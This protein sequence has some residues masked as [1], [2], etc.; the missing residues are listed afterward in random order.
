MMNVTTEGL[1]SMVQAGLDLDTPPTEEEVEQ[2]LARLVYAFGASEEIAEEAKR[3]LHARFELRMDQGQT[4]LGDEEHEPWLAARQAEIDPFYW[5]R[6]RKLLLRSGWGPRVVATLNNTLDE[7]LDLLGNPANQQPWKR[8]G[9][10]VGDVQSGKTATYAGL[11]NKASDAGY[12]M[13]I[14]LTG[15]LENVRRQ[16]QERLDAAFVGFDSRDYLTKGQLQHKTHIGVGQIDS[17]R[18]GVVFTSRDKDF[19]KNTASQLNIGLDSVKDPVLVV[20]KKNKAVLQRLAAWLKSRNADRDGGIDLPLLLIDDEADNASINTST[21]PK[22]TTAINAVIRDLLKLF[23]RSSYVGFTAT[24]FANIFIDPD[25]TDEWRDEDLFPKDFIHLLEPPNNYIGMETL[26]QDTDGDHEDFLE[27]GSILQ[28]IDDQNSWLPV[29]H[30]KGYEP[31]P[32]PPSLLEAVRWFLLTC[33]IRDL[34]YRGNHVGQG[35]PIHRSMLIN[36][37][38]FTD[39][40]DTVAYSVQEQLDNIQLAVR[41]HG[42]KPAAEAEKHSVEIAELRRVF[43]RQGQTCG[44]AWSSVLD[45]LHEAIAPVSVQPINQRTGSAVLDYG[46]R[47]DFPGIRVI[48]VGGNSLSRGITLEGLTVSYFLRNSKAYDTLLQMGRWFGYRDGYHDLCRLWMSEEAIG[49]YRHIALATAELKRDFRKMRL[50]KATP[51]EFG[52]RVRTHPDT[53][54]ITARNKMSSGVDVVEEVKEVSLTGRGIETARLHKRPRSNED[55]R[56]W[57]REFLASLSKDVSP[58][59]IGGHRAFCWKDVSA[60]KIADFAERFQVHPHNHDFQADSIAEHLRN[61]AH[62]SDNSWAYW[63]VIL[64]AKGKDKGVPW[65]L[66]LPSGQISATPSAR[67]TVVRTE[68]APPSLLVSGSNARIGSR[69]DVL[70]GLGDAQYERAKQLKHE[71]APDAKGIPEDIIRSVMRQ[72]LLVIYMVRGMDAEGRPINDGQILPGLAMHFPGERDPNAKKYKVQY[73]LNRVAQMEQGFLDDDDDLP[74]D[75][76]IDD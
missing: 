21:R 25:S 59:P 51:R 50:Q 26:F 17:R 48:A 54:I 14:L 30:K 27:P 36:V 20:S 71:T 15:T 53:L 2:V 60:N 34:R 29:D 9:L 12:R 24:P 58:E 28:K 32:L 22:E 5:E 6:Y 66:D 13:I 65:E 35:G 64:P 43:D 44:F 75:E 3:A 42:K 57:T 74:M 70:L 69:S 62:D 45:S 40:Q 4:I 72:P 73:R 47:R 33:A 56:E 18:D 49:W 23:Y 55:N 7:I 38:R 61:A 10:V 76:D 1:V 11:I 67:K 41:Q 37:S 52:L 8:R 68:P 39:I 46:G 19:R 16:T 63:T 31:G